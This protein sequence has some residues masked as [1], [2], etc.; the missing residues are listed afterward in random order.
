MTRKPGYAQP[1]IWSLGNRANFGNFPKPGLYS[2]P[3][4]GFVPPRGKIPRLCLFLRN[5]EW[6]DSSPGEESGRIP[7]IKP[8][9]TVCGPPY[10][11]TLFASH[12]PGQLFT[13]NKN[14]QKEPGYP[15]IPYLTCSDSEQVPLVS[16]F[17]LPR[18]GAKV[19]QFRATQA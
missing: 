4:R 14:W 10:L 17:T 5:K 8:P 1:S 2:P 15:K 16:R 19:A 7:A 11:G 13:V 18:V 9:Q 6:G 12:R 3:T